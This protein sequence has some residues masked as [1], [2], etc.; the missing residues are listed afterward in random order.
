LTNFHPAEY[1]LKSIEIMKRM[2]TL[3][4]AVPFWALSMIY[5]Q[6]TMR[7]E[8]HNAHPEISILKEKDQQIATFSLLKTTNPDSL[9]KQIYI[10]KSAAFTL[11][12]IWLGGDR[13]YFAQVKEMTRNETVALFKYD[14]QEEVAW[15]ILKD[16]EHFQIIADQFGGELYTDNG[17]YVR[18]EDRAIQ[19]LS[20][21]R[22]RDVKY[23]T[24]HE[25]YLFLNACLFYVVHNATDY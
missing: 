20:G 14:E 17:P 1:L 19:P 7:W 21:N 8:T 24:P 10:F 6:P 18:I 9:N 23:P 22:K 12:F 25:L 5:A 15:L 13:E 2:L 4:F 3:F 11:Q 16:G